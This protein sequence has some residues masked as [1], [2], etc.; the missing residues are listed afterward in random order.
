M[1]TASS[2]LHSPRLWQLSPVSGRPCLPPAPGKGFWPWMLFGPAALPRDLPLPSGRGPGPAPR[3][4][5][6]HLA[7]SSAPAPLLS[8]PLAVN[9]PHPR[10]QLWARPEPTALNPEIRAHQASLSVLLSL[11]PSVRDALGR[12]EDLQ[13]ESTAPVVPTAA[14]SQGPSRLARAARAAGLCPCRPL[15]G[16]PLFTTQ[17]TAPGT[18]SDGPP[19]TTLVA[20]QAHSLSLVFPFR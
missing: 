6:R 18:S 3:G 4:L 5:L 17:K 15:T 19:R 1:L 14:W 10:R 9:R 8:L 20:P 12:L 16:A 2:P 11:P 7:L 13:S